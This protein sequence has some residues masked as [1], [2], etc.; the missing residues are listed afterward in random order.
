MSYKTPEPSLTPKEPRVMHYCACCGGEIYEDKEYYH[1]ETFNPSMRT[2]NICKDCVRA[3]R[4]VA[5][6]DD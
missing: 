5:G 1:I 4:R 3:A 6:E 2:L